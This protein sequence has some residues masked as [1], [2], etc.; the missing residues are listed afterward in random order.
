LPNV[1]LHLIRRNT[2]EDMAEFWPV[3]DDP[4][5]APMNSI[6]K[7]LF[8]GTLERAD[9]ADTRIVRGDLAT[10]GS[11]QCG[12]PRGGAPHAARACV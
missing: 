5:A 1:D 6:P 4:Y 11:H 2:Y 7:V 8:S 3:S 12:R 9:W 10:E